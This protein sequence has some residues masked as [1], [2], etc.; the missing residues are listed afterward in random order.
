MRKNSLIGC[1]LLWASMAMAQPAA[2]KNVVNSTLTLTT[3]T[4]DGTQRGVVPAVFIGSD[5]VAVSAW[6][7]FE[8]TDSVGVKD[9]SGAACAFQALLG[10]DDIYDL[11]KF[12]VSAAK[13]QP[14]SLGKAAAG[15]DVWVV[16]PK[17]LG[18]PV[19]GKVK[20]A[21]HFNTSYNYYQL[22]V[23]G[24][25]EKLNG[26]AVVNLKGELIGLFSQ[27]GKQQS[28]TDAAYARDFVVTG[29]SQ[30]N[31]VMRRAR[32]RIALPESER[33]AVVALLL[34]NSQKP[35][36]H[37]ATI[38]EFIRKFPH[39]TDG[40]YAM[41]ML[42]LGKGDNAEAD[43]MLQESVAQASKKGE[44]HFNYANVIY[45]VLTGQQPIQGDAPVTW[46]LDKALSEVQQA[47]AADPQFIY[48]HLMAQ[49]IYAQA[50]YAD[51]LTL[52]ESLARM[53]PRLPETYLEMAQ[54]KEQLG[55]D[56]AEVLA[57]LE[58]S[59]EVCDTPYTATSAP[60][61]YARGLQYAKMGEYRKAMVDLGCATS[62]STRDASV[63]TS[64]TSGSRSNSRANS[65]NRPWATSS[66]PADS[67]PKRWSIMPEA[68]SL[69]LRV[70][71]PQDAAEAAKYCIKINPD[72]ADGYLILGIAQ[73]Q[74]DQKADG[75]SQY[76]EGQGNGNTQADSFLKKLK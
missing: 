68:G 60:Y 44:A 52:F 63:P 49:I 61:F 74:L 32:L 59:V 26:A 16:P 73:T 12:S 15:E 72:Y 13:V 66:P 3:Y 71:R 1:L 19:K 34:S 14:L 37:A 9:Y 65:T 55:A 43:R 18:A 76:R 22:Y 24:A 64:T 40:Y 75:H 5:G 41:T 42:A 36:D 62:I 33:E 8:G 54:C 6:K 38:R 46:T 7:P 4:A 58:K 28:A 2:V 30:N 53:E 47:N 51:A 48:Q 11:T 56:N 39:L 67:L 50:H 20:V 31:P 69:Y 23:G 57:L 35:S 25:S 10:A 17:Q 21:D 45:L 29:L 27:S 70:N